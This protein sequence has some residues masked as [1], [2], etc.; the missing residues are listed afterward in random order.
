MTPSGIKAVSYDDVEDRTF[1]ITIKDS[2]TGESMTDTIS[3]TT[4]KNT[5]YWVLGF[6]YIVC[7]IERLIKKNR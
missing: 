7:N 2:K 6:M 4:F 1:E 3:M 5:A